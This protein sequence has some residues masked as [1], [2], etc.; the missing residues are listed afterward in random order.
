M[1]H[2]IIKTHIYLEKKGFP[3]HNVFGGHHVNS[4]CYDTSESSEL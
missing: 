2:K 3:L 1:L 4:A